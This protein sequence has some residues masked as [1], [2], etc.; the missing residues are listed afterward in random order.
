M[1]L[2]CREIV[3]TPIVTQRGISVALDWKFAQACRAYQW[4]D[5]HQF[6]QAVWEVM[7]EKPMPPVCRNFL[8]LYE[9]ILPQCFS[10]GHDGRWLSLDQSAIPNDPSRPF[11]YEGHNT[12]LP[13]DQLWLLRAFCAWH[14]V[15]IPA[16]RWG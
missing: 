13:H 6:A 5:K 15:A 12:D 10:M 7:N 11:M 16:V 9:G 4:E 14:Y 8:T 1:I 2:T 3:W